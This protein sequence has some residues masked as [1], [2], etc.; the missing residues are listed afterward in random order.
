MIKKTVLL[1]LAVLAFPLAANADASLL[2][3]VM[4]AIT[5][6]PEPSTLGLLG[7][8]LIGVAVMIRRKFKFS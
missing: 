4:N 1:A 7:S 8:G 5:G 3:G 6:L 2:S